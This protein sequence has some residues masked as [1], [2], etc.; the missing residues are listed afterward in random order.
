LKTNWK[1]KAIITMAMTGFALAFSPYSFPEEKAE[2]KDT[3]G[4]I[5]FR[6]REG[7]PQ[8]IRGPAGD[9]LREELLKS[10]KFKLLDRNNIDKI[11]KEQGI[12]LSDCTVGDCIVSA[13]RMLPAEKIVVGSI[14][15]IKDVYLL[16]VTL[17][18]IETGIVESI[19]NE[20]C[21]SLEKILSECIPKLSKNLVGE[22][23]SIKLK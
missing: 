13:G 19:A 17:I 5:D 7:V 15:K 21:Q 4:V 3:V 14:N 16:N 20:R 22:M 2:K 8:K 1:Y 11:L 12:N 10:G 6:I 18:N 23:R 9:K